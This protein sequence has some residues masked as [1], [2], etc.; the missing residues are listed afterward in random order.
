M[1][2]RNTVQSAATIVSIFTITAA[3]LGG[4]FASASGTK[5]D[6]ASSV[7]TTSSHTNPTAYVQV[8]AKQWYSIGLRADGSVWTWGRNYGLMDSPALFRIVSPAK[9]DT[10]SDF[11]MIEDIGLQLLGLKK[12]G[13]VW[14]WGSQP[15]EE[16]NTTGAKQIPSLS[17]IEFITT[18]SNT[19]F[20]LKKDGTVWVWKR[21]LQTGE[22]SKPYPIK[23]LKNIK[24]VG[25]NSYQMGHALDT[26]GKVWIFELDYYTTEELS[27]TAP[28]KLGDL[29][30]LKEVSAHLNQMYG[31]TTSGKA[32]KWSIDNSSSKAR[33]TSKP[34]NVYPELK[35]QSL[36]VNRD[37][38]VLLTD[39]G[40]VWIDGKRPTGKGGKV[41]TLKNMKQVSAGEY[42]VLAI[43][44]KGKAWGFGGNKWN[45]IGVPVT[46]DSMIY[47]PEQIREGITIIV[48]GDVLY[49]PYTA[50]M[51]NRLISVPLR[52]VVDA[53]DAKLTVTS[54]I[55]NSAPAGRL[56]TITSGQSSASFLLNDPEVNINGQT[57]ILSSAP[58][59]ERNAVMIPASLL[60]QMG[61]Q[62]TWNAQLSELRINNN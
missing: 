19:G 56:Y 30:K 45:E 4:S 50:V 40:D 11:V 13:T 52:Q 12:D 24:S 10:P 28:K 6:T 43:D 38:A 47:T 22:S 35:I 1:K 36:D 7:S 62:V 55:E 32:I 58:Y 31:I 3:L 59:F 15:K 21:D 61:Y 53:L 54:L 2:K 39:T 51:S 48:D 27:I 23:G 46:S 9:L 57:T 8:E 33:L 18:N 42:H 25:T 14:E 26:E 20:A 5:I 49:T 60:K 44:S 41:K 17:G 16:G 37:Y 29:P 34:A